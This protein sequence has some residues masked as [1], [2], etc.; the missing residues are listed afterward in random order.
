V[1][2]DFETS[3]AKSQSS[4]LYWAN[5]YDLFM[6]VQYAAIRQTFSVR[7]VCSFRSNIMAGGWRQVLATAHS[8]LSS[9]QWIFISMWQTNSI[10]ALNAFGSFQLCLVLFGH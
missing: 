6:V 7:V 3:V 8:R 10:K 2:R 1:S 4:V 5:L 9:L